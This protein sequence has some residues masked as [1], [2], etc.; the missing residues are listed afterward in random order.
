MPFFRS[1]PT[2][3]LYLQKLTVART[4]AKVASTPFVVNY[5][6]FNAGRNTCELM[7]APFAV[8]QAISVVFSI[9]SPKPYRNQDEIH[10][11]SDPPRMTP[12]P[13]MILTPYPEFIMTNPEIT[14][15]AIP[16]HAITF[17]KDFILSPML[18]NIMSLL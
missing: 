15:P 14:L 17:A 3:D 13:I 16:I 2:T 18:V 11:I 1:F 10:E 8:F 6:S 5:R 7:V 12:I 9:S 4:A